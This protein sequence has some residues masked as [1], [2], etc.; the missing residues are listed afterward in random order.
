VIALLL[1]LCSFQDGIQE[2]IESEEIQLVFELNADEIISFFESNDE[3]PDDVSIPDLVSLWNESAPPTYSGR[4]RDKLRDIRERKE[5]GESLDG[6]RRD[7]KKRNRD[8]LDGSRE[9][10]KESRK[11]RRAERRGRIRGFLITVGVIIFIGLIIA[12]VIKKKL[13]G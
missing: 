2:P 11:K 8:R 3:I 1:I 13:G 10:R 5:R 9:D 12:S 6:E 4:L 7:R